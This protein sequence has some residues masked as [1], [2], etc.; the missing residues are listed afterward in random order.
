M[1][2]AYTGSM[3]S[4]TDTTVDLGSYTGQVSLVVNL[5]SR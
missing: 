2:N 3:Q 4:I 1:N 5:A